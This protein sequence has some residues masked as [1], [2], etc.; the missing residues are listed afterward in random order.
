MKEVVAMYQ[1]V[2]E[3][4]QFELRDIQLREPDAGMFYPPANYKIVPVSNHP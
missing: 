3:G 2:P 1:K 4:F